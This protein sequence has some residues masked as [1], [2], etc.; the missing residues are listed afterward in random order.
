M[1]PFLIIITSATITSLIVTDLIG[2]GIVWTLW[3][4][5]FRIADDL[6]HSEITIYLWG[7]IVSMLFIYI[8]NVFL[9]LE[10]VRLTLCMDRQEISNIQT[11]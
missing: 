10:N 1:I 5:P 4:E 7:M 2:L 11:R 9:A 8:T 3:E 6:S